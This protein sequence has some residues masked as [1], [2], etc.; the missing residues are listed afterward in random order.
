MSGERFFVTNTYLLLAFKKVE[1]NEIR[2]KGFLLFGLV[3]VVCNI[4]IQNNP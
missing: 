2:I 3:L 1:I 4:K